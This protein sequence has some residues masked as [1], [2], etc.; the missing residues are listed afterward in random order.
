[1]GKDSIVTNNDNKKKDLKSD[2]KTS[3]RTDVINNTESKSSIDDHETQDYVQRE[4]QKRNKLNRLS[5]EHINRNNRNKLSNKQIVIEGLT[6]ELP[7][8]IRS[9][10]IWNNVIAILVSGV[11]LLII[12]TIFM[13]NRR[14]PNVNYF[15]LI[16]SLVSSIVGQSLSWYGTV[17]S[18]VGGLVI[19]ILFLIINIV[20]STVVIVLHFGSG[21]NSISIYIVIVLSSLTLHC[22]AIVL[23]EYNEQILFSLIVVPV[24]FFLSIGTVVLNLIHIRKITIIQDSYQSPKEQLEWPH[25]RS[26]DAKD[27]GFNI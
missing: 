19:S 8:D 17:R 26:P 15:L 20:T 5:T 11:Y 24:I 27:S 10:L 9:A 6:R 25:K 23:N 18:V 7:R 2:S 16:V 22:I 21:K 1:M 13:L 3:I 12:F 14:G 4:A